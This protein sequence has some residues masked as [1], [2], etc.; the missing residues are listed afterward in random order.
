MVTAAVVYL[1]FLLFWGLNYRR[2]PLEQKLDYDASR[3]TRER[4]LSSA[5][6][7]RQVNAL[8]PHAQRRRRRIDGGRAVA[9]LRAVLGAL[10]RCRCS[11]RRRSDRCSTFYFRWAAIDG[12]TNPFFLEIIVNP[13]LLP[14]SGRSSLAHEWAHLAGYA[15]ESEAN[16]VA[17][18]TCLRG[19]A[20]ARYSGW[21]AA[22]STCGGLPPA[23][24]RALADA[25]SPP[26]RGGSRRRAAAVQRV[27]PARC[28]RP[29][30]APTTPTC[31]RIG[32][33]RAS[34]T[35]TRWCG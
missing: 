21:L 11:S 29:R 2:L 7:G 13:D 12:M 33:K 3:I 6:S 32:S 34:P 10:R 14:S 22:Y 27:E 17:W 30:G 28:A 24:R 16:F 19:D 18:L 1:W 8:A 23:D 15:D 35:T 25:L 26:V 5:A 9:A 20:R 31:G 4:A